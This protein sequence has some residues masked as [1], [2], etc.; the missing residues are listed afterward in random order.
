[1]RSHPRYTHLVLPLYLALS[2]WLTW[3]LAAHF[4]SAIPS[5]GGVFDPPLQAF[6]LG[7]DWHSLLHA[8][9][10]VFDAPIFH[11]EPRTL[12]YTDSMLGEAALAAPVFFATGSIAA[13]YNA[14]VLLSFA[15]SAWA[16][17][18]LV[19]LF[20]VPRMGAFLCGYL[21]AFSPY[22]SANLDLLNQLQTQLLP[23]GLFFAVRYLDRRT[24]RDAVGVFGVMALQF[25]F[26]LYYT[27]YL[28]IALGLLLLYGLWAG[29]WRPSRAEVARLLALGGAAVVAAAPAA[30]P[31]LVQRLSTPG[32]RRSLGEAALYSADVLDYFKANPSSLAASV[33]PIPVGHQSY[34]PGLVAVALAA[35]GTWAVLARARGSRRANA[36]PRP[37]SIAGRASAVRSFAA[38]LGHRGYFL[39]LGVVGFVLSLGPILHVGGH[40]IWVPLPYALL[41]YAIPGF[42]GMRAPARLAVLAL[43]ATVVLAGLGYEATR[44]AVRGASRA[45]WRGLVIGLFAGAVLGSL[46]R[47]VLLL[48]LP[49]RAGMPPVYRWLAE[50]PGATPIL[51]FPVPARD[52]DENE[53]HSLRQFYVLLHGKPRVDG[54]SGFATRRYRAFRETVQSFPDAKAL[55]EVRRMEAVFV[56]MHYGDYPLPERRALE[57]RIGAVP[58]LVPRARLGDDAVY[59]LAPG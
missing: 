47:P 56:V 6:L 37:R 2:I 23:L 46:V 29:T 26:G 7:W 30:W 9:A 52:A 8:P 4:G 18:R 43:L 27:H 31:A 1:M 21:F 42:S 20:R 13:G 5:S 54:S 49:T 14:L 15:L 44:G 36:D 55:A 58:Q 25:Y 16:V 22:R 48:T 3:P 11:P 32:F 39:V 34:S 33:L 59:E 12:T 28:A 17:Y 19:R 50:Q 41:Y 45:V 10:H 51:E 35:L 40:R 38:T 24:M 53:A 57:A